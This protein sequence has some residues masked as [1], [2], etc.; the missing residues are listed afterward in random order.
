MARGEDPD[1]VAAAPI[2]GASHGRGLKWNSGADVRGKRGGRAGS[3]VWV[4]LRAG[5]QMG[6]AVE[7]PGWRAQL[8]WGQGGPPTCAGTYEDR[9]R[10]T[11]PSVHKGP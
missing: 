8:D 7:R 4:E 3:H 5:S 9:P 1:S 10:A 6:G 2:L 11:L